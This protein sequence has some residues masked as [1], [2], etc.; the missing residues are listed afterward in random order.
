MIKKNKQEK[1]LRKIM[2]NMDKVENEIEIY[3]EDKGMER[4][5]QE[6]ENMINQEKNMV[7]IYYKCAKIF[8]ELMKEKVEG[9]MLEQ[10]ARKQIYDKIEER[11]SNGSRGAIKKRMNR[12]EE[13]YKIMEECG[14]Q[15]VLMAM[16]NITIDELKNLSE[17]DKKAIKEYQMNNE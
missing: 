13:I 11:Y 15:K 6:Y 14:G 8:Q 5:L 4:S 9:G 3:K 17:E 10:T 16:E 1:A 7:E 12:A 2:E